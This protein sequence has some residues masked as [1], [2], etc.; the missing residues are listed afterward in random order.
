MATKINKNV[1]KQIDLNRKKICYYETEYVGKN[2]RRRRVIRT[3]SIPLDDKKHTHKEKAAKEI[4]N[5]E[6]LC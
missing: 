5:G 3:T 4:I 1:I 2:K 6:Q